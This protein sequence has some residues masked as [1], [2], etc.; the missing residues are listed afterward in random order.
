MLDDLPIES[1]WG[2]WIGMTLDFL[3]MCGVAGK[4]RNLHYG[5]AYN[6]HGIAQATYMGR[7]LAD[8]VMHVNNEDAE[9]LHRRGIP[10]PPEP[11]RWLLV[12]SL[13]KLFAGMDARVDR[14]LARK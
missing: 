12:K 13:I 8:G 14:S 4:H 2:G 10:I 7:L 1:F 6:G 5:L 11:L 3:P 9:L